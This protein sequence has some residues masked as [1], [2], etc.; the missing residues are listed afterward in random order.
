MRLALPSTSS[1]IPRLAFPSLKLTFPMGVPPPDDVTVAVKVT[2]SPNVEGFK[3]DTST[4]VVSALKFAVTVSGALMVTVVEA[5]LAF[6]TLPVHLPNV[7]PGF[8][9]ATS[10]TMVPA[11]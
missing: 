9:V 6:A 8:A 3:D 5:L 2:D 11:A 4:V 10:D 7:K 1:T